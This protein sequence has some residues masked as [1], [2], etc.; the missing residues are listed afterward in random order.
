[1]SLKLITCMGNQSL[2]VSHRRL[3]G[4]TNV[5]MTQMLQQLELTI[6]PF[7]QYRCAERLHNLL[8]GHGLSGELILRRAESGCKRMS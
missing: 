1:M 2:P 4:V 3:F 7:R 8:D 5:L 6:S